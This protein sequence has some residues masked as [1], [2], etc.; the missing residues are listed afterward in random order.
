MKKVIFTVIILIAF[1]TAWVLYLQ[2]DN[3][4]FVKNLPDI[5][6]QTDNVQSTT[7]IIQEGT[8]ED[9]SKDGG[10]HEKETEHQ[11]TTHEEGKEET[12]HDAHGHPHNDDIHPHDHDPAVSVKPNA[13]TP[14]SGEIKTTSILT[15]SLKDAIKRKREMLVE[16]HGDIPEIDIYLKNF[17]AILEAA[18]SG[19]T[20]LTIQRT[21][22]EDLE[23]SRVMAKLFPNEQNIKLYQ[24]KLKSMNESNPLN[25]Q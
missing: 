5:P 1:G 10:S 25:Q 19:N 15:L 13:T 16:K 23:F 18:K 21:P 4:H 11:A 17:A 8:S 9:P 22:E 6:S 2:W 12:L 24:D 3:R 20:Q 14:I 7:T